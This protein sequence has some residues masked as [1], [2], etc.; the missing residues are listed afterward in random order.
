MP[1][2]QQI[3]Q[4]LQRLTSA[5][6]QGSKPYLLADHLALARMGPL[7]LKVMQDNGV[8]YVDNPATHWVVASF[9]D[10]APAGSG[11]AQRA[12]Q[13]NSL[14]GELVK[15][16]KVDDKLKK[17]QEEIAKRIDQVGVYK[18][19][20]KFS[21]NRRATPLPPSGS[22]SSALLGTRSSR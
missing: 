19:T 21:V 22:T 14:L 13:A 3:Q 12:S 4:V 17:T 9:Q 1:V 18:N 20:T 2:D 5:I 10:R 15:M 16:N 6:K 7:S 11:P 8:T